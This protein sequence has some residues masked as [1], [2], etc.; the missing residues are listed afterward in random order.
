ME[1]DESMS[2]GKVYIG[3]EEYLAWRESGRSF[4]KGECVAMAPGESGE[5]FEGKEGEV[6]L[7]PR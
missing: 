6:L 3:M 5:S 4:P 1:M 7:A 2:C